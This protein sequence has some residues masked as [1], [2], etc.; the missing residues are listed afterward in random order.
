LKESIKGLKGNYSK[1]QELR[2]VY[3]NWNKDY[4]RTSFKG[5]DLDEL[6]TQ[7]NYFDNRSL[8]F[9]AQEIEKSVP[10]AVWTDAT[11]HKTMEYGLIVSIAVGAIKE[12]QTRID[13]IYEKINK[14]KISIS[15]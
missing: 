5:S 7:N 1:I 10:T 8:G 3:F 11:G 6:M 12:Q 9:I 2:G 13:S 4:V 14:L 15:A